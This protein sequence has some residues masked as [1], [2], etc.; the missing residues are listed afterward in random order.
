M[1]T[2]NKSEGLKKTKV[3]PENSVQID[4]VAD[5]HLDFHTSTEKVKGFV[6]NFVSEMQYKSK[7]VIIVGGDI[8]HYNEMSAEFLRQLAKIWKYVL[9]I[10][11]NHD[12]YLQDKYYEN[13]YADLIKSLENED[14]I[15]FLM[16]KVEIFEYKGIKIAGTMMF[17][18][19]NELRDYAMWKSILSDSGFMTREFVIS[20][21][22]KDVEY[23]NR[24]I[25]DVDIFVS[26]IPIVNLDGHATTRNLF[27]NVDVNPKKGVLY[28]SG[29][30]HYPK[31]SVDVKSDYDAI[32]VSY[33]Y[34][35]EVKD[36]R[37]LVTTIFMK[38]IHSNEC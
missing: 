7:E 37:N 27:L 18:N 31:N 16:D 17:Y 28:L 13:R 15:K 33:G 3:K 21:N 35:N 20:Q 5:L 2:F 26:H 32:N 10:P 12:W 22:N 1:Y 14:N 11:G 25:N 24:V 4:V 19:V 34:P 23:Y 9:V 30:T 8:S 38:S 29:H 36:E 6:E